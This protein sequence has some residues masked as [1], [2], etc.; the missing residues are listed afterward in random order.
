MSATAPLWPATNLVDRLYFGW[1]AAL[2]LLILAF[3]HN[4]PRW[5]LYLG[6]H[7]A[8]V[9]VVLL[10]AA[11]SRTSRVW[12]F[13]HDWYPLAMFIVCFEEVSRLSF[14]VV[15][16]WQDQYI[17]DLEARLFSTPPTAW[18]GQFSHLWWV[19]E[20]M[21]IGYFGYFVL[22]MIVGGVL[23]KRQDKR[24]FRQVMTASVL[25]YLLCYL[26]FINFPV[27]GPRP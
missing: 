5:P 11:G 10:L 12:R 21:E 8:C 20:P 3:R 15:R 4:L 19:T 1:F 6:L 18:F 26:V 24:A 2:S 17:L 14:L 27:M 22:L 7:A 9:L 23:H 16:G 13:L 25:S